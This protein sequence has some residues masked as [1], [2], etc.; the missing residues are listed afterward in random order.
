MTNP[1]IPD[2]ARC[3]KCGYL[4]RGL[5][6]PRCPECAQPFDPEDPDSYYDPARPKRSV[7]RR[8]I[9][10]VGPDGPHSASDVF[11]VVLLTIAVITKNA[12]IRHVFSL[13]P[14]I[15]EPPCCVALGIPLVYVLLAGV[16]VD[17]VWRWR[18][19]AKARRTG[20]G[21]VLENFARGRTRWRLAIVCLV[22]C[23]VT[24]V[25]PW[26]VY[27]RFYASR[28]SLQREAQACLA[29]KGSYA[30]WRRVGLYDVE[31]LHG[32]HKGYIFFQ[33]AHDG[34]GRRYGFAYRPKGPAPW[35]D[36]VGGRRIRWRP[37]S[38]GWYVE[39]W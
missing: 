24:I 19:R 2:T 34:D 8:L 27:A 11:L 12:S 13:R 20:N 9:R 30:G 39:A 29:G 26:P 18:V 17:L 6:E 3:L 1:R 22:V 25:Y 5:P 4:L 14:E 16:I 33:V 38:P 21:R 32:W 7:I 31:Y 37:V 15:Y 35:N 28:R 36:R 23:C 10:L